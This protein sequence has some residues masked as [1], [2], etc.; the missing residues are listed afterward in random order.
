MVLPVRSAAG[1]T[2]SAIERAES[3]LDTGRDRAEG[4]V[5]GMRDL[6]P[7]RA[8]LD[9]VLGDDGTEADSDE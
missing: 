1:D 9:A 8:D 3:V 4:T 6:L 5:D 7:D 2:R